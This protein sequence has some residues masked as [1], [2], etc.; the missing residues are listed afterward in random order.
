[1]LEALNLGREAERHR[2]MVALGDPAV[3]LIVLRGEAGAGKTALAREA[4]QAVAEQEA[5]V[6]LGKHAEGE[7]GVRAAGQALARLL[8]QALEQ[9]HDPEA[10]LASLRQALGPAAAVLAALD[11]AF[12]ADEALSGAPL[13]AE[14]AAER[15][16]FAAV[17]FLRWV[18]GLG[19]PIL[20]VL[21]DWGRARGQAAVLYERLA[22]EPDLP[23]LTLIATERSGEESAT[24]GDVTLDLG[25]LSREALHAI[26]A[27]RLDGDAVTASA[28][29]ALWP[30]SVTPLVLIQG[31]AA[32]TEAGA[33][34]RDPGG[35]RFDRAAGAAALGQDAAQL[36]LGRVVGTA[37]DLRC[38]LD[39][40]AVYGDAAP[41]VAL[42]AVCALGD[43]AMPAL[44]ALQAEG[45]IDLVGSQAR[46]RHDTIRAAILASLKTPVRR[47]FAGQWAEHLRRTPGA[48]LEAML[49]LRLE[50]GVTGVG[51][52]WAPL[53]TAGAAAARTTGAAA[54]A[55]RFA[56]AAMTLEDASHRTTYAAVREA[57]L[58]AV[59]DGDLAAGQ[60]LAALMDARA[61]TDAQRLEA[62]ET[63]VFAAR[64]SGDHAKAFQIGRAAVSRFGLFAP[65]KASLPGILA[66]LVALRFTPDTPPQVRPRQG[67]AAH[68]LLNTVG[69]IAFER[70]PAIAV[71]MGARSAIH[72]ALRGGPFASA[73]RCMLACLT[74]DW[75]AASRWGETTF[76]RLESEDP[77]RA[78]AMQLALQFGLGLTIDASR[79][80]QE[81]MRLQALALAEG[82]LGVA[83][84]ANRDRALA[85]MRMPITLA[86][87]RRVLAECKA[88]AARFQDQATEPLIDA[89]TQMAVN[90]SEGGPEPWRLAGEV[91]DSPAFEQTCGPDLERVAMACMTFEVLLANAYG[92][93]ET[94]LS[95]WTRMGPRFE[96]LKHHPVTAIWA[97]HCGL[98]RARLGMPIRRWE[99]FV[100]DRCARFSPVSYAHRALALKA[101]DQLRKG[102]V[103]A[104]MQ[105]YE[106][107]VVA[108]ARS[109]FPMEHGVVACAARH[110]AL[111]AGRL[112]LEDRFLAAEQAA[113]RTLGAAA[114]LGETD[115]AAPVAASVE[116]G[117]SSVAADRASRAKTRLL[118]GAAHELRTPMQ[119]IQ[120]LLDLAADDPAGLDVERLRE[121]FGSLS[122]V[123]DD[124]T[125]LGAVEAERVAIV[126]AGFTPL[127]LAQT[128]LQLATPDAARRGRALRLEA[129]GD[130]AS[131]ALGDVGR[132]AQILR[133]LLTNA[134]R[135][136]DGETV[137][138]VVA[139]DT[140]LAFEVLDH[141][142]GLTAADQTR[143]F[144]PFVRGDAADRSEGTGLGLSLSR[145]L[146]RRMGGDLT[147]ENRPGGGA[148][149]RLT[150]PLRRPDEP[151]TLHNIGKVQ[152]LRIL[153]AEDTELSRDTLTRL[154]Q[155][156]GHHVTAVDDGQAALAAGR[157]G[158]FDLLIMDVRM[159]GLDGPQVLSQLRGE[160]A[161]TPALILSASV[162][163]PLARRLA[164][165]EPVRLA[166][167]PLTAV[168]LSRLATDFAGIDA[169]LGEDAPA[170][171]AEVAVVLRQ[172][173]AE[174]LAWPD[175]GLA[176]AREA[177]HAAAGVAAQFGLARQEA[178]FAAAERA[179]A[180]G[181]EAAMVTACAAL[182]EL[183]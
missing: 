24:A 74:G 56:A 101:E 180:D 57:G 13:T 171:R 176:A 64:L 147:G 71:V 118:A 98:A 46:L 152:P 96:G 42:E 75:A 107:A 17:R 154:L 70:N 165:L 173:V 139:T 69:S 148:V 106:A 105:T 111:Q 25:P 149:F 35:W 175:A 126:D 6:A 1:M 133:N 112:D 88:N 40:I 161:T 73:L 138:R 131:G 150:L 14:A 144:Q 177:A 162:D 143:L 65:E 87:H 137:L 51:D 32:L 102:Q 136:G 61:D 62:A 26:A 166:R 30:G 95:V 94:T 89:L 37:P 59:Q 66:A 109:G 120:G 91:F 158:G 86:A 92:A 156:Q 76:G 27:G 50:A 172:R 77:L 72:P 63:A 49:R 83:A 125:E 36:L 146:A 124:L 4:M 18:S 39:A 155:R 145:R 54:L 116:E 129:D 130:V 19:L 81:A 53:F 127:R 168:Q 15:L 28:V 82:D 2:L 55:R 167:K 108:A 114:M 45:L 3:R 157:A 103:G 21:D 122:A 84:Y 80:M 134:L 78:A 140:E 163:E 44:A 79:Q 132:L 100:V 117:G 183:G 16:A 22:R 174:V 181:D 7:T 93:W 142:P 141:G 128:E 41:R 60:D 33:L 58:A 97:F 170:M 179:A 153:L 169:V 11:P 29:I 48:D 67:A 8:D 47:R 113:W 52:D 160:G 12:G 159:P 123:V 178:A 99:R 23:G 115:A 119:G 31:L 164:G 10:G 38:L 121:A 90:L 135:Y 34:V 5:L 104:A 68:R 9:L 110:A 43:R 20:L 182:R 151:T 85:S